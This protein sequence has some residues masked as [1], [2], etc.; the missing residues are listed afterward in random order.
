MANVKRP[1]DKEEVCVC[2]RAPKLVSLNCSKI[3]LVVNESS[4]CANVS[5]RGKGFESHRG[6]TKSKSNWRH[7]LFRL[8]F[9][10]L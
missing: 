10:E 5:Q 9:S 3:Q 6:A 1:I 4:A 8:V 7:V 2:E